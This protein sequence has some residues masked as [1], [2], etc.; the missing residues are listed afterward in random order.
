MRY[1]GLSHHPSK[2]SPKVSSQS[3]SSDGDVFQ[4]CFWMLMLRGTTEEE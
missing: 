2:T 3:G 4:A 1:S